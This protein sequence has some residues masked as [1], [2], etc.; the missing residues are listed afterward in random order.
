MILARSWNL[1]TE[2]LDPYVVIENQV[3]GRR[4][5]AFAGR[6]MRYVPDTGQGAFTSGNMDLAIHVKDIAASSNERVLC[7]RY[8]GDNITYGTQNQFR[9]RLL[10]NGHLALAFSKGGTGWDERMDSQTVIPAGA[11]W[12]RFTVQIVVGTSQS[13]KFFPSEDAVTWTQLGPTRV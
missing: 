13:V 12:F 9:F 4:Y 3:A 1:T 5:A 2:Q 11:T 10:P 8:N 6:S 7:A